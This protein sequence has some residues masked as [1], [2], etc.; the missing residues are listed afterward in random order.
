[1]SGAVT[2]NTLQFTAKSGVRLPTGAVVAPRLRLYEV[3][4]MRQ[5]D[6]ITTTM[7]S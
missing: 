6:T 1:M 3:Q 7:N 5:M 4:Q 2:E